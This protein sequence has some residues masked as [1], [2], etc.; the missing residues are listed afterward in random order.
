MLRK[1]LS[2]DPYSSNNS[3]A[4]AH[5]SRCRC[6]LPWDLQ[7]PFYLLIWLPGLLAAAHCSGPAA[8]WLRE[9]ERATSDCS[10]PGESLWACG[11]WACWARH[12]PPGLPSFSQ[13]ADRHTSSQAL[14]GLCSK[15]ARLLAQAD[16]EAT[17]TEL[18]LLRKTSV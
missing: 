15:Q 18:L 9:T 5:F 14:T 8:E 3:S 6:K 13:P 7:L 2:R 11:S 4:E 12:L 10:P 1:S 16:D 17:R